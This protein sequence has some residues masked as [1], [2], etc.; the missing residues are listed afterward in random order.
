MDAQQAE[1]SP[2]DRVHP[3]LNN[4]VCGNCPSAP[5]P[6]SEGIEQ[7]YELSWS[8]RVSGPATNSVEGEATDKF[9]AAHEPEPTLHARPASR[10]AALAL[11]RTMNYAHAHGRDK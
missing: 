8:A 1:E 10:S 6:S 2:D 11:I 9:L 7:L 5:Q 3:D 4:L